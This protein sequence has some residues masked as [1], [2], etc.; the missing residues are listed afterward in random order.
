MYESITVQMG[1]VPRTR[2]A[3]GTVD[4]QAFTSA[5][6]ASLDV[7]LAA[8]GWRVEIV[9]ADP[10]GRTYPDTDLFLAL[11]CD[12]STDPNV[13][14]ASYFYPPR[15][16]DLSWEWGL[17]WA[18][19]HQSIADYRFGFR[20]P[21]Y[22]ARV[23]LFFYAWRASRLPD[24]ATNADV[25]LLAEHFFATNPVEHAWAWTPGRID[26]MADA[27]VAALAA[28]SQPGGVTTMFGIEIGWDYEVHIPDVLIAVVTPPGEGW[29]SLIAEGQA[30]GSFV[31][32]ANWYRDLVTLAKAQE[33]YFLDP[34]PP[35]EI[36]CPPV[37]VTVDPIS[38][39][40]VVRIAE[41]TADRLDGSTS[42][43][44][45]SAT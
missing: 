44:S 45:T 12:G 9:E 29:R 34:P 23:G 22:V 4:E 36:E 39:A 16:A 30:S 35:V 42:T 41:G 21:N 38:D 17:R 18:A 10:P 31:I 11:H 14:S 27:H 2:G 28:W 8:A 19:A 33:T 3:T 6:G 7:R 13:G 26:Q 32:P 25:C 40:D 24:E 5:L 15:A 43:L 20:D 1:H 37:E